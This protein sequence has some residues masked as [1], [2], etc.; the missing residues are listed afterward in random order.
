MLG[1]V[2]KTTFCITFFSCFAQGQG[3]VRLF[4]SP[5]TLLALATS[6]HRPDAGRIVAP[7]YT[8]ATVLIATRVNDHSSRVRQLLLLICL[9]TGCIF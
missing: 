3:G 4:L 5:L 6:P 2:S 7:S 8:A 1:Y 9:F